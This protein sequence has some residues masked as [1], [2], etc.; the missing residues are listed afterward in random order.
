LYSPET[1]APAEDLEAK[2]TIALGDTVIAPLAMP[3]YSHL[4]HDHTHLSLDHHAT[5]PG[6]A[7]ISFR[8][9]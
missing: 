6:Q 4:S 2:G 7:V 9:C 1:Q 8:K 3:F 5:I